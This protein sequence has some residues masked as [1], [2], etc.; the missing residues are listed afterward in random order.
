MGYNNY[1]EN[2]AET[3]RNRYDFSSVFLPVEGTDSKK[4]FLYEVKKAF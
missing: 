4:S 3:R 1:N 2:S